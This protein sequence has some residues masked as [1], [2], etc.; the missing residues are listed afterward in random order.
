MSGITLTEMF[1]CCG[2]SWN[3]APAPQTAISY[4]E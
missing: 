2:V 3:T 1:S 4:T